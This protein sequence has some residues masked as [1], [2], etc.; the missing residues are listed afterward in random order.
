MTGYQRKSKEENK[1]LQKGLSE[2]EPPN[3]DEYDESRMQEQEILEQW[4]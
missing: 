4:A 3:E 1:R 2:K